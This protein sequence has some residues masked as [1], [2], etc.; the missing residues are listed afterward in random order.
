MDENMLNVYV[1]KSRHTIVAIE[2]IKSCLHGTLNCYIL[3]VMHAQTH[4]TEVPPL[5]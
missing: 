4:V 5:K 1:S 3:Y 2:L